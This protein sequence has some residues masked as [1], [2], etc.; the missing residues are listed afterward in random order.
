MKKQLLFAQIKN[1]MINSIEKIKKNI[2]HY[3][4]KKKI[5]KIIQKQYSHYTIYSSIKNV[6]RIDIKIYVDYVKLEK[7]KIFP[8]NYCSIRKIFYI[9]IPKSK[10]I[11]SNKTIR[12]NFIINGNKILDK[13]YIQKIYNGENV[14]EYNFIEYDNR[15]KLLNNTIYKEFFKPKIHINNYSSDLSTEIGSIPSEDEEYSN[16]G[17]KIQSYK[18]IEKLEEEYLSCFNK[19]KRIISCDVNFHLKSILKNKLGI[20]LNR[21]ESKCENSKKVK[22]GSIEFSY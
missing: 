7:F 19:R 1:Q 4:L 2:N 14:N 15:I 17:K 10:F 20:C 5:K 12:F 16:L 3:I 18:K 11:K 21:S 6:T 9:N 13:S 22:F 8:M